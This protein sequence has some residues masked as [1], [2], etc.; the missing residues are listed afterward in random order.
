MKKCMLLLFFVFCLTGCGAAETFETVSDEILQPVMGPV[1]QIDLKLPDHASVSVMNGTDGG[2]LYLC[3][4]YTLTVQT[5]EGGDLDKTIR[6][7]C[8]FRK[9]DLTVL[10]TAR[11]PLRCHEWVWTCAG[12]A[13]DQLGRAM[14]LSEGDYHYC[15]TAMADAA[16]AASLEPEWNQLFSSFSL[17]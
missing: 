16:D 13:G 3:D 15:L 5:L 14:V 9:E 6:S 4:G 1:R 2:K 7:L 8:G 17:S 11:G 10:Q 12:E